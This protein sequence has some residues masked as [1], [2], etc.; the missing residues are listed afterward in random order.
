MTFRARISLA[1]A[2]AVGITVAGLAGVTFLVLSGSLTRSADDTLRARATGLFKVAQSG[3]L[4]ATDEARAEVNQAGGLA[5]IVDASGAVV[6]PKVPP[7][8]VP[9][10]ALEVAQGRRASSLGIVGSG[11]RRVRVLSLDLGNGTALEL[12]LQLDELERDLQILALVLGLVALGGVVLAV[13]MG[14]VVARTALAPID[15]LSDAIDDV[16]ETAD[17]SRRVQ[18]TGRDELARLA[19][20]FNHLLAA[21]EQSRLLQAQLVADASHELR[22]P[23]TSLRT[24]IEVLERADELDPA[25]REALRRDALAQVHELT[26]LVADVVELARGE[27][28]E[29]VREEIELADLVST[30]VTRAEVHARAVGVNF[31]VDVAPSRVRGAPGRLERAVANLLD[32]AVKWSPEGGTVEVATTSGRVT[33]RD[34]GPGIPA[35]DLPKVFDRFY[36]ASTAR[37]MPGSGLGLAIVREVVEAEGGTVQAGNHS[38]GGAVVEIRLPAIG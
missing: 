36:R 37:A 9:P 20:D 15:R 12:G 8:A 33:V 11:E 24:N 10:Q 1:T 27:A 32:N 22:T 29:A 3:S 31:D 18:V 38:S 13:V 21:L 17:L 28:P 26:K 14:W 19:T 7:F 6:T 23:L 30:T 35:A 2:V 16:A 25:D 5:Q 34:H 4:D